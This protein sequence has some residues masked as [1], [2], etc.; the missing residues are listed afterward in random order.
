MIG[1]A[2]PVR[3]ARGFGIFFEQYSLDKR[4][5]DLPIGD[6]LER[7]IQKLI[8][9]PRKGVSHAP[10]S[11][12]GRPHVVPSSCEPLAQLMHQPHAPALFVRPRFHH[13]RDLGCGSLECARHDQL[14]LRA[15]FAVR[16]RAAQILGLPVRSANS[17]YQEASS[18]SFVGSAC[19]KSVCK[20]ALHLDAL[21]RLVAGGN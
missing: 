11:A 1:A 20:A 12:L 8:A 5:M 14:P 21:T 13:R 15:L 3:F 10:R 18:R 4:G 7:P 6:A 17:R 9:G 19:V 2:L 16:N